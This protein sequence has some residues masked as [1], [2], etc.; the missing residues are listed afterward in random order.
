MD[1]NKYMMVPA[2]HF[3]TAKEIGVA[4][5]TLGAM[6]RRGFVVVAD[7]KPKQYK[8]IDTPAINVYRLCEEHAKEFDT[9]FTL[10]REGVQLGMMCSMSANGDILDCWGN[11]YDLTG[12][13]RIG[14]R[15]KEYLL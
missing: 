4:A 15:G 5:A 11:K 10:W 12:V 8:R 14:F 13:A 1:W 3:A 2:D 7:T 6:A 9:Y